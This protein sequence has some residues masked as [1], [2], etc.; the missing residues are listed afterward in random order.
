MR[1]IRIILFLSWA[2]GCLPVSSPFINSKNFRFKL[3]SCSSLYSL[4]IFLLGT[5]LHMFLHQ[6]TTHYGNLSQALYV[7]LTACMV[8]EF[9]Q[10]FVARSVGI[11]HCPKI[12]E[13]FKSVQGV[14]EFCGK[15][16]TTKG[17][18][19]ANSSRSTVVTYLMLAT[20]TILQIAMGIKYF[21]FFM[22]PT[23]TSGMG[24]MFR[25]PFSRI[26]GFTFAAMSMFL[27]LATITVAM[28][29]SVGMADVL[30]AVHRQFFYCMTEWLREPSM[31]AGATGPEEVAVLYYNF[32]KLKSCFDLY[33]RIIGLY[34]LVTITWFLAGVIYSIH[35]LIWPH[36]GITDL[37]S[38]LHTVI[39]LLIL[40]IPGQLLRNQVSHF[41]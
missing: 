2:L 31:R 13:F 35:S 38:F 12:V 10:S 28:W 15:I 41:R 24:I 36:D 37:T 21:Y 23:G 1:A 34:L 25:S 5:L 29:I 4:S 14:D 39:G 22:D 33:G 20:G 17:F 40:I 32:L 3:F 8:A 7:N 26:V 30:L 11:V 9:I 6:N 18:K 16:S 27:G 19:K